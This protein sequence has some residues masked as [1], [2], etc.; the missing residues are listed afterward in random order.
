MNGWL[1]QTTN[2]VQGC[3]PLSSRQL[4]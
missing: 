2:L 1:N 3:A 4:S